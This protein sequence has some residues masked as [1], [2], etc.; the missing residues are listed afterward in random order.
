MSQPDTPLLPPRF[1]RLL[2]ASRKFVYGQS[3]FWSLR[4]ALG[5]F[6]PCLLLLVWLDRP[7][8]GL[9]AATSALYVGLIDL[10][11]PLSGKRREMLWCALAVIASA[12]LITL[13]MHSEPGLWLAALLISAAG[14]YAMQF[15]LKSGIIGLNAVMTMAVALSLRGKQLDY[16]LAYLEGVVIGALWYVAF[17]LTICRLFRHQMHRRALADELFAT[18]EQFRARALCYDPA[19]SPRQGSMALLASQNRQQQRHLLTRELILGELSR[20]P[21]ES[22]SPAQWQLYN[23]M[24]DC[25]ALFD[26]VVAAHTDFAALRQPPAS[27]PLLRQLR[28]VLNHGAG[29]LDEIAMALSTHRQ[30]HR[31]GLEPARLQQLEQNLQSVA[32]TLPSP[33]LANLQESVQRIREMRRLIAKL[34]RDLRSTS[35]TSGFD[36]HQVMHFYR[37][38]APL[39]SKP[40]N[41]LARP[42]TS[43]AARLSLAVLLALWLAA[44]RHGTHDNWIVLTVVVALRPGFGQSWQRSIQRVKGTVLGCALAVG[45]LALS[46]DPWLLL[47]L[48]FLSLMLGLGLAALDYLLAATFFSMMLVWMYYLLVPEARVIEARLLDTALGAVI[49]LLVC[50]LSPDWESAQI[51]RRSEGLMSALI[52]WLG[53]LATL[54][55]EQL[56]AWR[57]AQRD[58]LT[59][60]MQLATTRDNML[61]EPE[62]THLGEQDTQDLLLLGH[63][64]LTLGAPLARQQLAQGL[65]ARQRQDIE[66]ALQILQQQRVPD[67]YQPAM[68]VNLSECTVL[69]IQALAR[70]QTASQTSAHRRRAA[71]AVSTGRPAA[72]KTPSNKTELR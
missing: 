11:G 3:L 39:L 7:V 35:N 31:F 2:H 30:L 25:V 6:L 72:S 14:A 69:M 44:W 58:A 42:A 48:T 32:P 54:N 50:H 12:S 29:L 63:L 17:A 26:L 9:A 23:L 10:P 20:Q 28:D 19:I 61:L 56:I 18:A 34:A 1:T 65:T 51:R 68:E 40:A 53:G 21:P 70:L 8:S 62:E 66:Q 71:Q 47:G 22:L 43:Y 16:E 57:A 27:H 52:A 60:L 37:A 45:V 4:V 38:P 36:I 55:G 24:A 5:T 49:A 15:G 46:H 67:S 13:A 59:A 33:V 41:W 64:L